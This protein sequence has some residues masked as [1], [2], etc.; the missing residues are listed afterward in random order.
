MKENM[1]NK[2][3]ILSLMTRRQFE[4][5]IVSFDADSINNNNIQKQ[6]KDI[7]HSLDNCISR[8]KIISLVIKV[9]GNIVDTEAAMFRSDIDR[10][11]EAI[12]NHFGE[13]VKWI[14]H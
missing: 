11:K 6:I 9:N 4:M 12:N 3:G 13:N 10:I 14:K 1:E 7:L 8:N 5:D 2:I